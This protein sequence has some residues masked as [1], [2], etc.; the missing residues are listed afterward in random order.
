MN[1][2][3]AP[4]G[5]RLLPER[6]LSSKNVIYSAKAVSLARRTTGLGVA[7][8]SVRVNMA[9]V[10][11]RKRQM[12]DGLVKLHLGNFE[13]SGAELVRGE[14]RFTEPKTVRVT[15]NAGGTQPLRGERVFLNVGTRASM[16]DAQR[17]LSD[18]RRDQSAPCRRAQSDRE[19]LGLA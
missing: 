11:R 5:R 12:V 13:A 17:K 9:V 18:A 7:T 8:G 14:A 6:G 3:P 1:S 10:A 16:P 4:D 15:L 2:P 19:R